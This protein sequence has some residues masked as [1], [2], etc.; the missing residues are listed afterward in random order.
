MLRGNSS[1]M[2]IWALNSLRDSFVFGLRPRMGGWASGASMYSCHEWVLAGGGGRLGR[3][4]I[5]SSS[6]S[7]PRTSSSLMVGLSV[8]ATASPPCDAAADVKP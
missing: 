1:D 3:Y 4:S 6:S 2:A 8:D 7:R 5:S